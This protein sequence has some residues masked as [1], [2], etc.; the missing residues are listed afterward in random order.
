LSAYDG[1]AD[2][3]DQWVREDGF[4]Q[5][6]VLPA[7]LDL[8]GEV[9]GQAVCDLACGQGLV[10]RALAQRGAMV[11]GIDLS[12]EMLALAARHESREPLG[13]RYLQ[14]DAEHLATVSAQQFDGVVCSMALMDCG[15]PGAVFRSVVRVLRPGGWL[16]SALTHPC[17]Q[18]P[19]YQRV[20]VP[21]DAW[22]WQVTDYFTERT[23]HSADPGGVR[24][25]VGAHHRT[26]G[27]Y[28]N[29]AAE[30]GLALTRVSEPPA[31]GPLATRSPWY[32]QV[33]AILCL[34]WHTE[35]SLPFP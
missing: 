14:D 1:I 28:L 18:V 20:P 34:R 29:A 30:A 26:L 24:S 15:D 21:P 17:F 5:E 23:W 9:Q 3:Y 31:T 2:W 27:S 10:A 7:V 33:P 22:A 16:V 6:F 19:G 12:E 35:A 4:V 13:V 8:V 25:R 32:T 11:T